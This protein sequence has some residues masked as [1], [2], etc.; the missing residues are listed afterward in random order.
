MCV[1]YNRVIPRSVKSYISK[2]K[3]EKKKESTI[4]HYR[5]PSFAA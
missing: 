3:K 1:G 4:N 2:K 5:I